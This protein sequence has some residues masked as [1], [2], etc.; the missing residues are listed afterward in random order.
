MAGFDE[1]GVDRTDGDLVDARSLDGGERIRV[2]RVVERRRR[3]RRRGASGTSPSASAVEHQPAW[4]RVIGRGDAEQVVHLA[5]EAARPGKDSAA[6]VGTAGWLAGVRS[7]SSVSAPD[8]PANRYTT[9]NSGP[10]S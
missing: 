2:G 6:N 7:T 9:R 1:A 8:A 4:R 10:S 5:F 3:R